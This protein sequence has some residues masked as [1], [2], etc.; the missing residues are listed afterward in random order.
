MTTP[1][2]PDDTPVAPVASD[3]VYVDTTTTGIDPTTAPLSSGADVTTST[4]S[5][6]APAP[7]SQAWIVSA[8]AIVG[9]VV[10]IALGRVVPDILYTI[11]GAT[12]TGA[13]ALSFSK[14]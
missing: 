5:F 4:T 6:G 11:D 1:A 8:L 10:L 14:N 13:A 2:V 3:P 9:T 7:H 12:I